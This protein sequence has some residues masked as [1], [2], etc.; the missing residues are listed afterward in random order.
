MKALSLWQPWASLIVIG[1]K[2]FETRGWDTRYRGPLAIHAAK[3]WNEDLKEQC[4]MRGFREALRPFYTTLGDIP[5]GA[6]LGIVN[7]VEIISTNF[8][9]A[10]SEKHLMKPELRQRTHIVSDQEM[11]FG[12]YAS[13]RFAWRL[14]V[15]ER[16]A[17][18][19]PT[20]G[21]QGLFEWTRPAGPGEKP[22]EGATEDQCRDQ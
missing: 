13:N 8:I 10:E 17:E 21:M 7:L 12:N 9:L 15:V 19:I 4:L 22:P 2:A 14:E 5:R 1:A 3:K 11:L 6:I 16:F 18:P 20:K